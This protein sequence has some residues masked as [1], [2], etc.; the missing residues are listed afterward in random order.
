MFLVG[1]LTLCCVLQLFTFLRRDANVLDGEKV[2]LPPLE[3]RCVIPGLQK[4]LLGCKNMSQLCTASSV[5][6]LTLVS[7]QKC[8]LCTERHLKQIPSEMN[9]RKARRAPL[10][11]GRRSP[12]RSSGRTAHSSCCWVCAAPGGPRF[13]RPSHSC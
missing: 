9:A 1:L 11:A 4:M 3:H 6:C 10:A 13:A 12:A 7:F 5:F 8:A 2:L